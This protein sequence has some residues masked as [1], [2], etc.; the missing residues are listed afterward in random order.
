MAISIEECI[1]LVQKDYPGYEVEVFGDYEGKYYVNI[2]EPD[3]TEALSDFHSVDKETGKV[4]GNIAT[5]KIL[6]D[7]ALR[8]QL[9]AHY[10]KKKKK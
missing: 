7:D 9:E 6:S 2:F 8:G 5:M 4:S 3:A 10:S 1:R